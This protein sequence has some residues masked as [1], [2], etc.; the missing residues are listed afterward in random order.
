MEPGVA[1]LLQ[2]LGDSMRQVTDVG[3]QRDPLAA[4]RVTGEL[5]TARG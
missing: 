2:D 4:W 3:V 1:D 5:E